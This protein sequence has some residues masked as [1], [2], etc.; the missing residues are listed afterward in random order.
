MHAENVELPH[1]FVMRDNDVKYTPAFDAVFTTSNTEV[2]RNTPA[3]P[4]LRAHVERFIQTLQ[5][6]CLDKFVAVNERHLNLINREF[7]WWYNHE[8]PHSARDYL[9]PGFEAVSSEWV[10]ASAAAAVPAMV[11]FSATLKFARLV[12]T[13][14]LSL[15]RVTVTAIFWTVTPLSPT[16]AETAVS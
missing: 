16:F 15:T 2:K 10:S 14:K 1:R 3:S 12:K 8:R 9:P 6:E 4:N 11:R 7:Q 13:G 5:V